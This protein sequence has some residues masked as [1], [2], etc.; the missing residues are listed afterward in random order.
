MSAKNTPK[1][2]TKRAATHMHM[3]VN[4]ENTPASR[5][6]IVIDMLF[7]S[8]NEQEIEKAVN[9]DTFEMKCHIFPQLG[10]YLH[11]DCKLAARSAASSNNGRGQSTAF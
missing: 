11:Q 3:A 1:S 5:Y 6:D 9:V 7:W 8:R 2:S 10:E 4:D